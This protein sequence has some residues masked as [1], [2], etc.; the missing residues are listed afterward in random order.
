M[1]WMP[2]PHLANVDISEGFAMGVADAKPPMRAESAAAWKRRIF[3]VCCARKRLAKVC[4]YWWGKD[5][6]S[7]VCIL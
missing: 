1:K 6:E 4:Y 3:G 7:G 2:S 5:L